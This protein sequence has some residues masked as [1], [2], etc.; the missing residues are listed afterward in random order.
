MDFPLELRL[1]FPSPLPLP[2]RDGAWYVTDAS[3]RQFLLK[4]TGADGAIDPEVVRRLGAI[5]PSVAH[6]AIPERIGRAGRLTY[7]LVRRFHAGS[8]ADRLGHAVERRLP[9]SDVRLLVTHVHAALSAL[10]RGA[11]AD[12]PVIHCDLKPANVLID[13][14]DDGS[15]VFVVGDFDAALVLAPDTGPASVRR[16]YTL[17]YAAPELLVRGG[18]PS[19]KSDYWSLGIMV[20]EALTGRRPFAEFDDNEVYLKVAMHWSP[21]FSDIRDALWR[22]LLGGLLVRDPVYRWGG[23]EVGR[24]LAGDPDIVCKGLRLAGELASAEPL[25]VEGE[26]VFSAESLARKLLRDWVEI[27]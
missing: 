4:L 11:G 17:R 19:P 27:Q 13:H 2:G 16:R 23:E 7:Q 20:L 18:I 5:D 3:Q 12:G 6:L 9:D 21:G 1:E 25:V 22:A 26:R 24:W 8:L 15:P 10:H 14:R